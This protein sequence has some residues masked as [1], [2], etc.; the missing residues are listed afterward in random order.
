M[1]PQ[2]TSQLNQSTYRAGMIQSQAYRALAD[3]MTRQL[4]P[5]EIS[6]SEW[7]LLGHLQEV[8]SMIPSE[9]AQLLGIKLPSST[10]LL[11]NLEAKRLVRRQQSEV[12]SRMIHAHITDKG[13]GLVLEAEK[14]LRP[15]L[16]KFLVDANIDAGEL[17]IYL[18]VL[19]KLAQKT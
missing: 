16:K 12:D 1:N 4:K 7:K 19:T 18:N 5:F 13:T 10:R 6:L 14:Q 2:S 17:I 8:D 11:K 3:F 9:I 15:Q